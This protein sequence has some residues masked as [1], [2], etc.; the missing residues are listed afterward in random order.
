MSIR[1]FERN[2]SAVLAEVRNQGRTVLL[3]LHGELAAVIRPAEPTELYT[4][5]AAAAMVSVREMSDN[6]SAVV[7]E[8][9][10][11]TPQCLSFHNKPFAVVV[12]PEDWDGY[13]FFSGEDA[14]TSDR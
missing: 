7:R 9:R 1:T 14:G 2:A 10:Q 13:E 11:G 5:G 12:T 8:V 3:T 6:P 4:T